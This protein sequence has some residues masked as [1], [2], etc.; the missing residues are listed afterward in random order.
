MKTLAI[1]AGLIGATFL[2]GAAAA[3]D[4]EAG[5]PLQPSEAGGI[6]SLESN[7]QSVCSID[8]GRGHSVRS[9]S[10]CGSA[11]SSAPTG[12]APTADG[13]RLV[14]ADGQTVMGFHRWSNSLFVAH[15]PNGDL[16]LR[17]GR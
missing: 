5:V 13:M 10:A 15:T 8:L 11:L 16:Q 17:R 3:A 2:A 14:S 1:A 12:W 6:W 7:G 4:N 9:G